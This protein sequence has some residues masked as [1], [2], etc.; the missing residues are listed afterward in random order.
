MKKKKN[1]EREMD[2]A[3]EQTTL[4]KSRELEDLEEF[5]IGKIKSNK[6]KIIKEKN[7]MRETILDEGN[8]GKVEKGIYK[9]KKV[10]IKTYS[11]PE[12]SSSEVEILATLNQHENIIELIGMIPSGNKGVYLSMITGLMEMNLET[13]F[14]D[15][16][17]QLDFK[18]TLEIALKVS[19]GLNHLHQNLILHGDLKPKNILFTFSDKSVKIADFGHSKKLE[20]KDDLIDF[21]KGSAIFLAYNFF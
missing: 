6:L 3:S 11:D 8:Y 14:L 20:K 9:G 2:F 5:S 1:K 7:L 16:K 21:T 13:L 18:S 17:C 19:R 12:K 4:K 10:A 15:N